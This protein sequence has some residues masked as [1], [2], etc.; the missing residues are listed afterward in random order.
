M[1]MSTISDRRL[2]QRQCELAR[3]HGIPSQLEILPRGRTDVGD[4]QRAHG[5]AAVVLDCS[6]RYSPTARR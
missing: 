3:E 5:G 2:I 1:D 4:L 6:A